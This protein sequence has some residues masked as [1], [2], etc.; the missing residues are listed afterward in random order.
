MVTSNC[1]KHTRCNYSPWQECKY[2]KLIFLI[3]GTGEHTC[4]AAWKEEWKAGQVLRRCLA[5]PK[6]S[7]LQPTRPKWS[8]RQYLS[9]TRKFL[10]IRKWCGITTCDHKRTDRCMHKRRRTTRELANNNRTLKPKA[11]DCN[12]NLAGSS[13]CSNWCGWVH[14]T[15][16]SGTDGRTSCISTIFKTVFFS[17]LLWC[18]LTL[19][20]LVEQWWVYHSLKFSLPFKV[21]Y[22]RI[23]FAIV[24]FFNA[25]AT[26]WEQILDDL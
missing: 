2:H 24:P 10:G 8:H 19:E 21:W 22:H 20:L 14:W 11:L 12:S 18:T 6:V 17:N 9:S 26:V 23:K 25:A 7:A 3:W 5:S 1:S 13:T 15:W 16:H 4:A